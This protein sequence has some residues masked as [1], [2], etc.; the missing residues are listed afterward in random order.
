MRT[1]LIVFLLVFCASVLPVC[2][3]PEE[4]RKKRCKECHRFS[5]KEKQLEAPDLFYSGDKFHQSWLKN[6]LQSPEMIR[7]A[8]FDSLTGEP[9]LPEAH[10][11]LTKE[12]S[13]RV[14]SFLMTLRLSNLEMKRVDEKPLSKE[15]RAQIKVLFERRFGC[16]SCHRALNLVGK[17]RGGVSGPSLVNSGRRLKSDW[18]FNWLTAPKKFMY[19]GRMP[20]F[21][22]GEETAISM[23]KYILSIRTKP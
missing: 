20:V 17:L 23:T 21:N 22:L 11:A 2:A 9:W 15:K 7:E 4:I 12:E 3:E 1:V 16:I 14:T 13:E 18:I 19:E 10:V 8:A 5:S 6:F